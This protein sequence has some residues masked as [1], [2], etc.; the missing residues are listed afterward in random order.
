M[1]TI[2]FPADLSILVDDLKIFYLETCIYY[3]F[4]EQNQTT[5]VFSDWQTGPGIRVLACYLEDKGS[6]NL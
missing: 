4:M 5:L 2:Q 1:A 3:T 6:I